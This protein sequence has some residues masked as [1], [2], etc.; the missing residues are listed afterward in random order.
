MSPADHR[1]TNILPD[2]KY[3]ALISGARWI[4]AESSGR[5]GLQLDF[6][7]EDGPSAIG[8]IVTHV[9]WVTDQN[10]ERLIKFL[11]ECGADRARMTNVSY[12]NGQMLSVL[13]GKPVRF[14]TKMRQASGNFPARVEISYVRFWNGASGSG[15]SGPEAQAAS[16]FSELLKQ[17]VQGGGQQPAA[18]KS[19]FPDDDEIPF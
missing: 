14:G 1:R 8:E 5:P 19:A 2:E 3:R 16:I 17:P 7:V 15:G 11:E 13:E 6:T 12:V 9:W 10:G 18:A 4:E